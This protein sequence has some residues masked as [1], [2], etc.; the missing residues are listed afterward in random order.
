IQI[1]I[2]TSATGQ[3]V[4]LR[5]AIASASHTSEAARRCWRAFPRYVT[6]APMLMV[7]GLFDETDPIQKFS[8]AEGNLASLADA[9]AKTCRTQLAGGR[10]P[11]QLD[12]D[13]HQCLDDRAGEEVVVLPMRNS[14]SVLPGNPAIEAS[15][16]PIADKRTKWH[17][18]KKSVEAET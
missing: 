6:C 7:F 15:Q 17:A 2:R 11:R 1:R 9:I 10:R 3:T 4:R 13:P 16:C 8:D 18:C 14:N 12:C 5:N